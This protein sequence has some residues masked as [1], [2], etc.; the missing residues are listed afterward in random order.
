MNRQ[1]IMTACRSLRAEWAEAGV[2]RQQRVIQAKKDQVASADALVAAT[3]A[4][5]A[6]HER[7]FAA[8]VRL[9]LMRELTGEAP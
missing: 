3:E 9:D 5:A 4:L 8:R 1:R 7:L 2:R 6:A